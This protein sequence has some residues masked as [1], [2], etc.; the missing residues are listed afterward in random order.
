[1][2]PKGG[3]PR[4]PQISKFVT[5]SWAWTDQAKGNISWTF[6]NSDPDNS[7]AVV[8]Y[9]NNY[10]FGG[11]FWPV[12]LGPGFGIS[13][14]DG[15]QPLPTLTGNG[16]QPMG[17]IDYGPGAGP[18]YLVHFI[19]NLAPGQTWSTPEG[20]FTGSTTPTAGVC[21][22]LVSGTA[23][24]YCVGYDPTRVSDYDNLT[25]TTLAGYTPNPS[26]YF[27]YAFTPESGTPEN[28]L[29][30]SDAIGSGS[31]V[32]PGIELRLQ[33]STFSK[34]EV[35]V[36]ASFPSACLIEASGF[37]NAILGLTSAA[38]L[39]ANAPNPVPA[40]SASMQQGLNLA[41]TA[42]Q[43]A[44]IAANL[45]SVDNY[46]P[47]PI[48][49][50]DPTLDTNYQS[51]YYPFTVSFPNEN[52]FDAL[53][54][55][56]TAV[57]T[58]TAT[59]AVGS[60]APA[61]ANIVLS[62][63]ED[64]FFTDLTPSN[65][66]AYPSWLSFD[67]RFFKA[68]PNQQHEMF[69]VPNPV[70]ANDAIRYI[71]A[72]LDNLNHPSQITNGD[73][74]DG[75]LSQD[76]D[77]SA[78]EYL[79]TGINGVP[80]FNFAVARVRIVSATQ[81]TT[82]TPVRVFFRLF[83]AASTVS[84][85]HEV[86]KGE[87]TYRWGTD[88]SPNHKIPLLGVQTDQ[89]GHLEYVTIP[90]FATDRINLNGPADMNTQHDDPNALQI[91]TIANQEVDTYFGCWIDNNQQSSTIFIGTPP[92]AQTQWDGPWPGTQSLSGAISNAPHQCMIAEI[93]FDDTP[94]PDGAN[95][96]TSDKLAQR[97]IA[98][99]DGPNPGV[100]PSRVMPHPFEIRASASA[101]AVDELMIKWG[102]TPAQSTG[103]LYLPAV[104]AAQILSLAD[105]MYSRHFLTALDA[106]TIGCPAAGVTLV[107]V[108]AGSG[109]YAG[110]VAVDLP[111]GIQ[112]GD[113]YDISVL[114][115]EQATAYQQAPPQIARRA[116]KLPAVTAVPQTFSWRQLMGAFECTIVIST[117]ENLL[118]PE[119]RLLAW[120]KWRLQVASPTSRWYP[121]LQ[122]YLD[123]IAGRVSGFGGDPSGIPPSPTGDVPGHKPSPRPGHGRARR[124][125]TGKVVGI[126]YDR[127][128]DFEGFT[129]LT[130]EGHE[131]EFRGRE[132]N[133]EELIDRAWRERTLIS[134][135]V[136]EHEPEWP[137][138][139][140]LRRGRWRDAGVQL[141][142]DV[143]DDSR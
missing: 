37:T 112:R 50:T 28:T 80:T 107:P 94:I 42:A 3:P 49:A 105:T 131:R 27:T 99:I 95:S 98:W 76:E 29:G 74:F 132:R 97:N 83:Q 140:V 130:L 24:N 35:G 8:L 101:S 77:A 90:C 89:N 134:V 61:Y 127:F 30:F 125:F 15:S 91:T 12:Y 54:L 111:P 65:P 58:L 11:A 68:T 44:T 20:G 79:P 85:F 22:E 26:T 135:F 23:G 38:A 41:L 106:N 13:M 122:R 108:P 17:I 21:Y 43:F 92:S 142:S 9:R 100:A 5:V 46:G 141:G 126:S 63:G 45:P 104:P 81:A 60:V 52:A 70:G 87:G 32:A 124:E 33:K 128:G 48:L 1:M 116:A 2:Q 56:Q 137:A 96:A 88:G 47:P 139:V 66:L 75:A 62:K 10:V 115:F 25:G 129:L 73:T 86:G 120:L 113:I 53:D 16:G 39:S 55:H 72:V 103:S 82:T 7:H 69:S 110:L 114:Q 102:N 121:V 123:L 34:D 6:V 36:H 4:L 19:F 143:M 18:R 109:R 59:F 138:V 64:P 133:V 40:I 14:L 136:E 78:L 119:E 93:R 84:D 51:V 57:I 117:N 67:L 31:C 71:H 118:Y